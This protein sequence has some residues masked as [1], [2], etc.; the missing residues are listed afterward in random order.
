MKSLILSFLRIIKCNVYED[1]LKYFL[2]LHFNENS[3]ACFNRLIN[4][5]NQLISSI[6]NNQINQFIQESFKSG[7]LE[8]NKKFSHPSGILPFERNRTQI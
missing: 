6:K 1:K 2:E 3:Q 8:K 7:L 5:E 4:Y